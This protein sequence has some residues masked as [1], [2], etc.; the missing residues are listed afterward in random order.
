MKTILTVIFALHIFV[1]FAYKDRIERPKSYQFVFQNND[2]IRLDNPS[3]SLLKAY[4]NDIV[5]GKKKLKIAELFF[6]T[7][8]TITLMNDGKK[9]TEIKITDGKK[10][11]SVPY[12]TIDKIPEIHIAT[13]ALLWDGNDKQAFNASYF[14]IQFDIGTEISYDKL[15]YLQLSFS[16]KKF[17]KVIVWRQISENSKQRSEY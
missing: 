9:W 1:A 13:I 7:G 4:N 16:D 5:T 10:E 3:D 6:A 14:H 11:V 17:K 12:L 2:T 15:P 8:E